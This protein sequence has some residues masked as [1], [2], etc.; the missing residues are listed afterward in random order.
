MA[1]SQRSVVYVAHPAG[2]MASLVAVGNDVV[3]AAWGSVATGAGWLGDCGLPATQPALT[4]SNRLAM[5]M[6]IQSWPSHGFF[7]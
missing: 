6:V 1:Y 7:T 4:T 5:L 2:I 3:G